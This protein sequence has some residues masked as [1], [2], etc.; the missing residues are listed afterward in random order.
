MVQMVKYWPYKYKDL[1]ST[2]ETNTEELGMAVCA[3]DTTLERC[4]QADPWDSL[5]S[6]PNL[7]VEPQV[8][9]KDLF[10]WK[11]VDNAWGMASVAVLCSPPHTR[12]KMY[13]LVVKNKICHRKVE[14]TETIVCD[15]HYILDV[16]QDMR[17][18]CEWCTTP[19][20]PA[21]G[22]QRCEGTNLRR[23]WPS[24]ATSRP[25]NEPWKRRR[26]VCQWERLEDA[27]STRS[28]MIKLC[29]THVWRYH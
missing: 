5:A 4:K 15:V 9:V 18:S 21:H 10:S 14:R 26:A 20:A 17:H 8:P 3:W 7:L 6:Q 23:A 1:S 19:A 27:G 13:Y 16:K 29:H 24:T 2:P 12:T 11:K 28:E 22:S 25:L